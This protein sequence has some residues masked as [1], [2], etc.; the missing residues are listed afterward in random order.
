M[1]IDRRTFLA[2]AAGIAVTAQAAPSNRVHSSG[3]EG[4]PHGFLWGAAGA[5]HQI[6]G[7]NISSDLWVLENCKPTFY[8]DRSGDALNSFELWPSDLEMVKALGLNTYRFS[9]EWARIEPEDSMFSIAMLDYYKSIIEGCRAR[10]ITPVVTFNHAS[11]PRWFAAGG[12]WTNPA[13]PDL[14]SRFCDRAARH[15]SGA[16]AYAVTLNEPN[17][18]KL[19][20]G[21]MPAF[22]LDLQRKM[23]E[24]AARK[25]GSEK[26]SSLIS[27]EPDDIDVIVASLI[28]AHKLGK[29][30]IKAA[31]SNLP[32]GFTLALP[33]DEAVGPD[34][35]RDKRRGEVYGEWLEAARTDDFIGIQNYDRVYWNDKGMAA[36]A[37]GST[38]SP[39]GGEVYAPSLAAAVSYAYSVARVPVLVTEH[40]V[41]TNDDTVRAALIPAALRGLKTAMG[42]GVDVKGYIHWSLMDNYEWMLGYKTHYG[43]CSVDRTTFKRSP[44]QSAFVLRD[45]AKRNSV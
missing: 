21:L 19:S 23:L 1:D 2:A 3:V 43:L 9:L 30:A 28:K 41:A 15:L 27:C 14:F 39:M 24:A 20:R 32:V 18:P 38:L 11:T 44:K 45:V 22:V 6:E 5:G 25:C 12:G 40:G 17:G 37:H 34:S 36:P 4:F 10:D 35:I 16:I 33:D 42:Q 7:N 31:R 26:F 13:S 8:V 29:A